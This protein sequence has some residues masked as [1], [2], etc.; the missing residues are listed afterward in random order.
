[1]QYTIS[2]IPEEVDR[3]A[4]EQAERQ[5]VSLNQALIDALKSGL[6]LETQ[7]TKKRELPSVFD[8]SPLEPEVLAILEDQRRIDPEIWR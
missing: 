2:G 5:G 6:G 7:P 3:A 8:G 1:M 4:R